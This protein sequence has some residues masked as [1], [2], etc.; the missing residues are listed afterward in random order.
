LDLG[1]YHVLV[2]TRLYRVPYYDFNRVVSHPCQ[3]IARWQILLYVRKSLYLIELLF[4]L[5]Y[6][7]LLCKPLNTTQVRF[8]STASFH[9]PSPARHAA[10]FSITR[11]SSFSISAWR[12]RTK[13][14]F[15]NVLEV[16]HRNTGIV[17]V[18]LFQTS[19][20]KYTLICHIRNGQLVLFAK[21]R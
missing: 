9:F 5:I 2:D 1:Y 19:N 13:L 12:M 18:N 10:L 8:A 21:P 6:A 4:T 11:H 16:Q 15:L 7:H 17:D 20:N 3:R 14:L